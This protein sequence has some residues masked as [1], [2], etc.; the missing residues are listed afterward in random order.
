MEEYI[1]QAIVQL[2]IVGLFVWY[3]ERKENRTREER[4]ERDKE[5]RDWMDKQEEFRQTLRD[6][7]HSRMSTDF[8]RLSTA[9]DK[10][11]QKV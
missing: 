5:W 4:K 1:I 2:P 8:V 11:V 7:L 3:N 9:I 6:D 10:L